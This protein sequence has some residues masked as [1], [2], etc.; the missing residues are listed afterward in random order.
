M[1][2]A[3]LIAIGNILASSGR[4]FNIALTRSMSPLLT[5]STNRLIVTPST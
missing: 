3:M 2:R 5:A 4:A 1:D